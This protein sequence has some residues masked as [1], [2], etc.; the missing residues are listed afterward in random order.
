MDPTNQVATFGFSSKIIHFQVC[1]ALLILD[2]CSKSK[3]KTGA[4]SRLD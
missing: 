2:F 4:I 3:V 1:L